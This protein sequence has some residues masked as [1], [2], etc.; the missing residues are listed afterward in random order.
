MILILAVILVSW[1][2]SDWRLSNMTTAQQLPR[3]YR[4]LFRYGRWM[5][6]PV[7]PGMTPFEFSDYLCLHLRQLSTGSHWAAWMLAGEPII[8]KITAAYVRAI[9]DPFAGSST[10]LSESG[11]SPYDTMSDY[12]N[13]R[14][15]LWLLWFLARIYKYWVLRPFFWSEAPLFI[16]SFAEEKS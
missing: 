3:L 16:S 14:L 1:L 5:Q 13:L 15:R 10:R 2:I 8:R 6:L 9:F 11:V 12:K 4:R 7:N